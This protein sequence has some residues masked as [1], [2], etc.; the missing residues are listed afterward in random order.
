MSKQFMV[1]LG[2]EFGSGGHEIGMELAKRL[3]VPFYDRNMLD[4]IAAHKNVASDGLHRFDELP[5]K[6]FLS[7]TVRGFSN[8]PEEVIAGFQFEY[9]KRK[10]ESGESFVVVGRCADTVLKNYSGLISIFI[11][12]DEQVKAE[13]VAGIRNITVDEA[14]AV[15]YRHDKKRKAYHNYYSALKWGDSRSYDMTINSSKSGIGTTKDLVEH[16]VRSRIESL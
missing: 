14:K 1:S 12:G 3:G 8:S 7:R 16:Y 4:E 15:M 6:L 2:R 13:R 9:I 11:L 5:K 10:A